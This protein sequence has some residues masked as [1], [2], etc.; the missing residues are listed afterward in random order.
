MARWD[1][2]SLSTIFLG[3]LARISGSNDACSQSSCYPATGDLLIGREDR[4]S[5]TSTCGLT[6][7]ER[8]CIVSHLED[9]KKCFRCDS[10]RPYIPG[11]NE[12]SHRVENVVSKL[13]PQRKRTWWQAENGGLFC[14]FLKLVCVY[15]DLTQ[16][17]LKTN[18]Y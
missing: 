12:N 6:K 4:L 1:L 15:F 5:S 17:Y 16:V 7:P 3:L 2:W 8:Y 10:R 18:N 9:E 11:L 14:L 13:T